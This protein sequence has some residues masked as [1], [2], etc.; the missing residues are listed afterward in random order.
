MQLSLSPDFFIEC[1][2]EP[3]KTDSLFAWLEAYVKGSSE[4][5]TG[6]LPLSCLTPFQQRVLNRLQKLPFGHTLSY[7]ELA[8]AIGQ[9]KAAR[10]IGGA[11]HINPFPLFI[12]CHRIV[13][14]GGK[15]GGFAT[16]L[17]IK[18]RLLEFEKA[19]AIKNRLC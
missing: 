3:A 15:L 11:C 14:A 19:S 4:L 9:P 1:H 5:Y 8:S 13:A 6:I 16:D 17:E 18:R 2:G 12:P 7:G 10:A